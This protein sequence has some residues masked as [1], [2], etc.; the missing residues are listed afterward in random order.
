MENTCNCGDTSMSFYPD[1][2]QYEPNCWWCYLNPPAPSHD[3]LDMRD[4]MDT[5]SADE[6]LPF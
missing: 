5:I 1:E 6:E 4:A 3:I 2:N